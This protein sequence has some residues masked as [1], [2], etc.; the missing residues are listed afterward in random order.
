MNVKNE[1]VDARKGSYRL[2]LSF[3]NYLYSSYL[4]L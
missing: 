1:I 2:F 3:F 4:K